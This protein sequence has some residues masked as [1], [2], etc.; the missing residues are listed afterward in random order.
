MRRLLQCA[1]PLFALALLTGCR[2]DGAERT[3][4]TK[5]VEVVF[6]DT[7]YRVTVLVRENGALIPHQFD[8]V[9]GPVT[10]KDDVPA[11]QP[12]SVEYTERKE[13]GDWE[14]W[15]I[16]VHVHNRNEIDPGGWDRGKFGHG[17][18]TRVW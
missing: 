18:N 8:N 4:V 3:T 2:G 9:M 13:L 15:R 1:L 6:F 14:S 5:N 11:D 12:M 10:Y 7:A 17:E 16:V